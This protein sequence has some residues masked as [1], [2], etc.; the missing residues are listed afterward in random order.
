M[1][2]HFSLHLRSD[3]KMLVKEI[4]TCSNS[5][6]LLLTWQTAQSRLPRSSRQEGYSC[7]PDWLVWSRHWGSQERMAAGS[8]PI[9]TFE[10]GDLQVPLPAQW[11]SNSGMHQSPDGLLKHTLL[12]RCLTEGSGVGLE[13]LPLSSRLCWSAGPQTTLWGPLSQTNLLSFQPGNPYLFMRPLG[14]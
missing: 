6:A 14:R 1:K 10:L 3:H 9:E 5:A 11:S 4:N 12:P 8:L 7:P 2:K 13:N